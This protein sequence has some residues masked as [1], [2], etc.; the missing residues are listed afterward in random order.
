MTKEATIRKQIKEQ[1]TIL[2]TL[3]QQ[4]TEA[5]LNKQFSCSSCG[6]RSKIKGITLI[7]E[8]W[9][10]NAAYQEGWNFHEY[11][12]ICPK[13]G[14]RHRCMDPRGRRTGNAK[15]QRWYDNFDFAVKYRDSF[16]EELDWYPRERGLFGEAFDLET[17]RKENR[18]RK[19][20]W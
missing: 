15:W 19:R 13:C 5:K 8:Y 1:E 3:E 18:E 17:I 2:E 14:E 11:S 16:G 20:G 10:D 7:R 4:L 6:K 12:I 9:Y